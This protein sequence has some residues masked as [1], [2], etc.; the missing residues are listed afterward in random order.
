MSLEINYS[1]TTMAMQDITSQLIWM[2]SEMTTT[3]WDHWLKQFKGK[4]HTLDILN[5]LMKSDLNGPDIVDTT[6]LKEAQEKAWM[7]NQG[8]NRTRSL[9]PLL[10]PSNSRAQS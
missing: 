7:K 10:Q 8:N 2:T 4:I 6:L 3:Y 1:A 5:L 9:G